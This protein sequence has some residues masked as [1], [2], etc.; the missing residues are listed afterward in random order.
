MP[1]LLTKIFVSVGIVKEM[2]ST[3]ELS[4]TKPHDES[5]IVVIHLNLVSFSDT[6]A[7]KQLT[8]KI[9]RHIKWGGG[10]YHM[11]N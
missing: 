8:C 7:T 6:V 1:S 3:T 9:Y 10:E 2:I 5:A 11:F 4:P